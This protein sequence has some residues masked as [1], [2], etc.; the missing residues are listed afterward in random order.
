MPRNDQ[1]TRQWHL[2]RQLEGSPGCGTLG[3]R[4]G[5]L[6]N[7]IGERTPPAV[8]E[9][10]LVELGSQTPVFMRCI[11]HCRGNYA[12]SKTDLVISLTFEDAEK[13]VTN[14]K[15]FTRE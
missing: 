1:I 13:I 14:P 4:P 5:Y 15:N 6:N 12:K 9:L 10:K 11:C 7:C 8:S 2:L 3:T